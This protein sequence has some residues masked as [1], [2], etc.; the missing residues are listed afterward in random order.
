MF[1]QNREWSSLVVQPVKDLVRSLQWLGLLLWH[2]F[3]PWPRNFHISWVQ[4][5][6]KQ[7]TNYQKTHELVSMKY[8]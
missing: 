2:R 3:Y 1:G 6:N 4:P 5:K 7:P 8:C